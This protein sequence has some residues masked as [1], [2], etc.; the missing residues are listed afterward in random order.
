MRHFMTSCGALAIVCVSAM[1]LTGQAHAEPRVAAV[2]VSRAMAQPTPDR[3]YMVE[4]AIYQDNNWKVALVSMSVYD[5]AVT[6]TVRYDNLAHYS[7]NLWCPD[8]M[9]PQSVT[10]EG[11][12]TFES[13]SFCARHIG[14]TLTLSARGSLSLFAQFPVVPD[15]AA[16]VT[17]N[18]WYKWGS[19]QDIQLVPFECIVGPGGACL[20]VPREVVR[21]SMPM[22]PEWLTSPITGACVL[23]V[24][25]LGRVDPR[26]IKTW[27]LMLGPVM[28]IQNNPKAPNTAKIFVVLTAIMPF[29]SC[30]DLAAWLLED[31]LDTVPNSQLGIIKALPPLVRIR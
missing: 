16:Q 23:S 22:P 19:V 20:G 4:R 26:S 30:V 15:L 25:T 28:K 6:A 13:D 14:E 10:I 3:V 17:L 18:D 21:S 24:V 1:L 7:Q 11:V 29:G 9:T 12:T 5:G 2:A 27:A 8:P 31:S